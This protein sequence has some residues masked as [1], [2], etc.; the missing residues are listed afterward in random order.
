MEMTGQ[1]PS[2]WHHNEHAKQHTNTNKKYTIT[3]TPAREREQ[4]CNGYVEQH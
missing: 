4:D 1:Q 2:C 3:A